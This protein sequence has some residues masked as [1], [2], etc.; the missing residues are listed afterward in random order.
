MLEYPRNEIFYSG[1]FL[2]NPESKCIL[3]HL[4]DGNTTV[5]PNQWAFFGGSSELGETPVQCIIR[6][7]KEELELEINETQLIFLTSYLNKERNNL[8]FIFYIISKQ[9]KSEF[10]LHEGADL[11]WVPIDKLF[12]YNLTEKTRK[13]LEFF[14]SSLT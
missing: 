13:D 5:H 2:F 8:R 4:R 1:C 3:L 14:M 9:S 6:E 10:V 7:L 12:E 11:E